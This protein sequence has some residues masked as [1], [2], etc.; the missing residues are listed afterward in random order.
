MRRFLRTSCNVLTCYRKLGLF[1]LTYTTNC[2]LFLL[3]KYFP[4]IK[5]QET[6]LSLDKNGLFE[7]GYYASTSSMLAV[8]SFRIQITTTPTYTQNRTQRIRIFIT[9]SMLCVSRNIYERSWM[10][11]LSMSH[12]NGTGNL[13]SNSELLLHYFMC[14]PVVSIC[15]CW[16]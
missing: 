2:K 10:L 8:S 13:R 9:R 12:S 6:K 14:F 16:M 3:I 11:E 15:V 7:W 4:I 5:I 1:Q